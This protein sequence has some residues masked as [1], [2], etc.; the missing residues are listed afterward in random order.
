MK[1]STANSSGGM[2][3]MVVRS[4]LIASMRR[5]RPAPPA[6]G[7]EASPPRIFG[8]YLLLG[9]G[10]GMSIM[11]LLSI[12]MSEV[13]IADAGLAS[14]FGNVTLQVGAALG[15][16][17]LGSISTAQTKALIVQGDPLSVALSGGFRLAFVLAAT[18]VVVGLGLVL[19]LLR[20]SDGGS[21]RSEPVRAERVE[22]DEAEAE[23]A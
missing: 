22:F 12:S 15:L 21:R 7:S 8:A 1:A 13:P 4:S 11:P 5:R 14:G 9:L 17:V 19:M 18:S 2:E 23:A 20:S 6:I 3:W 10:A 16:A